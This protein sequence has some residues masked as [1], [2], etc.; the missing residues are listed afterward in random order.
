MKRNGWAGGR[1][2]HNPHL[3]LIGF[4]LHE[5]PHLIGFGLKPLHDHVDWTRWD[6][7]MEI[8]GTRRFCGEFAGILQVF[9]R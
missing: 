4:L 1:V 6:S 3:W 5:T 8:I 9:C 7:D 2:H